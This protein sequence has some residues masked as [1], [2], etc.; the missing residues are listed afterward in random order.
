VT[1]T[2]DQIAIAISGRLGS[3]VL[4]VDLN[5]PAHGI[6]GF[7]GPSGCGKTSILRFVAGLIHLPGYLCIA[8]EVWQD[9]KRRYFQ[10]THKRRVGYVFQEASLFPH[11]SVKEN[12][13]FGARRAARLGNTN[14][15]VFDDVVDLLG[16]D[17][18]LTRATDALSGGERQRVAVGRALLSQ[19]RILLMDEPLSALDRASKEEILPYFEA[20]HEIL[21]IPVLYVSHDINELGKLADTLVLLDNGKI[22]ANDSLGALEVNAELPLLAMNDAAVTLEGRILS[23]DKNYGLTRLAVPGGELII[24][25][26]EGNA[27]N[28]LRLRIQVSD[29]SFTRAPPSETTILNCLEAC[30]VSVHQLDPHGDQLNVIAG[31]GANGAG[32]TIA[33]RITRRSQE[34]LQLFEGV[35]VF[36]QIKSVAVV[37]ARPGRK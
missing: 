20:L 3:F 36:V 23:I 22:L 15:L 6:S 18:L 11:L 7:F 27:G 24:P 26:R 2:T 1:G 5:L 21:S 37:S 9:D 35:R 12:L 31:L 34:A 19:P 25:W 32:A 29:V 30:I 17:R 10:K 28:L 16:I 13:L 4:D 14:A 33:G 8:D